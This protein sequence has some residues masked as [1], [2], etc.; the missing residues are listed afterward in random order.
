MFVYWKVNQRSIYLSIYYPAVRRASNIM[1]HG[2]DAPV[3]HSA[4]IAAY[5]YVFVLNAQKK[6]W[7]TF[8]HR[9][10]APVTH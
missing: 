3:M 6:D 8:C 10:T 2:G 4:S 7:E 1:S 9:G 5:F